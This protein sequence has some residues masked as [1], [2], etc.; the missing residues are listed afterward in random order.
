MEERSITGTTVEAIL[1]D[2]GQLERIYKSG[3]E[4]TFE[5]WRALRTDAPVAGPLY[6]DFYQREIRAGKFRLPDVTVE[7]DDGIEYVVPRVY[8][9]RPEDTWK[10]EGTS[11]FDRPDTFIGDRWFYFKLPAGTI[12]PNGILIVKDDFNE[13]FNARHYSIVPNWRMTVSQF[14]CLLDQLARNALQFTT[15]RTGHAKNR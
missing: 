12:I 1:I 9:K 10:A 5:L 3:H 11:L 14:K 4:P 13:R 8:R 2:L 15:K 6:P 7:T